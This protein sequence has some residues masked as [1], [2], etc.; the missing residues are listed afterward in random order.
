MKKYENFYYLILHD[1]K[2]V[3]QREKS[4]YNYHY[5]ILFGG[6]DYA[7]KISYCSE[8]NNRWT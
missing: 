8:K 7:G 4:V 5:E 2:E 1:K 6:N 3:V